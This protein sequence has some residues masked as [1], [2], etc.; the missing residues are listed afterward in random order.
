[1]KLAIL[2]AWHP[3]YLNYVKACEDLGVDYVII[4][5]M[6]DNWIQELTSCGCDGVLLRPSYFK[7]Y[8]K[9][10]YDERV[11]FIKEYLKMPIYPSFNEI[12]IYE[13]KNNMEYW[14]K[15][16]NIKHAET[17]IFYRKAEAKTFLKNAKYPLVFKTKIGSAGLGVK[18]IKNYSQG[19][20]LINKVFP[21][22]Y[23][24]ALGYL[25]WFPL[26]KMKFIKVPLLDD[27]QYGFVLFQEKIKEIKCEWRMIKIGKSYFGHQ[28][29][30]A[31]NGKHSGSHL[32][33]WENP[34]KELLDLTKHVCDIGN[35]TSMN[36]DI[37]ETKSGEYF[38]NELQTLFGSYNNSQMYINGKPGRYLY[39]ESKSEWIFEEGYFSQNS[40]MNL[41][42]EDFVEKLNS[43]NLKKTQND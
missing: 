29:L 7:Q 25:K 15:I 38:V 6:A 8:W 17:H 36:L 10:M 20:R 28:K 16:N 19:K 42:V 39:N 9:D 13:N 31:K 18:F 23:F 5:I 2:K 33:G 12:F 11:Y 40:S 30:E 1:M 26:K 34:P 24:L 35:F 27:R 22:K 21:F 3:T 37:F 14:L 32:V 43:I 41:R 4:D